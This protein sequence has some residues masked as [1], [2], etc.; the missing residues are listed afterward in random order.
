MRVAA[1]G[2]ATTREMVSQCLPLRARAASVMEAAFVFYESVVSVAKLFHS[3]LFVS[4]A[5]DGGLM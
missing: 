3:A 5:A 1:R 4:A 2:L